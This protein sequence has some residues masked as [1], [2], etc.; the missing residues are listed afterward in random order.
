MTLMREELHRPGGGPAARAL[1]EVRLVASLDDHWAPGYSGTVTVLG[2]WQEQADD[3]GIVTFDLLPSADITPAGTVYEIVSQVGSPPAK[4][5]YFLAPAADGWVKDHLTDLPGALP[6]SGLSSHV[7]STDPHPNVG[8]GDHPGL[9]AHD[10]LGLATQLE[11]DAEGTARVAADNLRQLLAEKGQP[12]GYADLDGSGLV[13][14]SRLPALSIT[15]VFPVAS[16]AAMLALVAE[17]GDVAIREDVSATFI[18]AAAPASTLSNWKRL[19]IP[20]DA[21][22]SVQGQTGVVTIAEDGPVAT[23]S[24]RSLGAGA[25]Q[26]L[27]GNH[28]VA[29]ASDLSGY[30]AKA[31]VDAK[32]DLI[33][34]TGADA[35]ARL[36]AGTD[37][38]VLTADSAQASGLTWAA[39]SGGG[40]VALSDSAP[41]ALGTAAAGVGTAASRDD[42]VHPKTGLVTTDTAQTI[43]GVKTIGVAGGRVTVNHY[44]GADLVDLSFAGTTWGDGNVLADIRWESRNVL[45]ILKLNDSG[46]PELHFGGPG[47]PA[48]V[49]NR[50]RVLVMA[51]TETLVPLTVQGKPLQSADLHQWKDS[52]GTVSLA[53]TAAGLPKWAAA[54]N[55]QTTVGA[56]GGAAALPASPTKYL[57]VVGDDGVTYVVPAFAAA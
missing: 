13:P 29:M 57:K 41:I 40:G 4:P 54:G 7:D 6:P 22:L 35:V 2:L 18:L 52:A 53:V 56:A 55:V 14:V 28:P 44:G 11:L 16:E 45:G 20:V 5:R 50:E 38:Y 47:S 19:P 33:V 26:A 21:V 9:A 46:L 17:R 27:P 49:V 10:T 3:L 37:G 25:Q 32:G 12:S 43:S 24:L 39:A 42:H 34:A 30:V 51:R 1:A 8:G 15:D 23:P 36:A 31:L 48:L